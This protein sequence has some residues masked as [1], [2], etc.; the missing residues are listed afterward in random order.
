MEKEKY[1]LRDILI[2]L[3]LLTGVGGVGSNF[4]LPQQQIEAEEMGK[5]IAPIVST[6][7]K[8][9]M[10]SFYSEEKK[11]QEPLKD[12][13]HT[14]DRDHESCLLAFIDNEVPRV[15][16]EIACTLRSNNELLIRNL[17]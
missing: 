13:I 5:I 6:A 8:E 2:G 17:K 4:L 16:A 3:A 14:L 1:T 12:F 7:V 9:T 11:G 15:S 10:V